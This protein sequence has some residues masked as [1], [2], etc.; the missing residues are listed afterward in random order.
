MQNASVNKAI[1]GSDNDALP[2][3]CQAIILTNAGLPLNGP[4]ETNFSVIWMKI[5]QFSD[6]KMHL[7]MSSANWWPFCLSLNVLI[8]YYHCWNEMLHTTFL[9]YSKT[10]IL[11]TNKRRYYFLSCFLNDSQKAVDQSEAMTEKE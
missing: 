11:V 4:L 5:Q 7:K 2:V 1:F 9:L 10:E 3:R 8:D 6:N